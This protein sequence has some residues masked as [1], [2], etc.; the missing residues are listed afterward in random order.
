MEPVQEAAG[1]SILKYLD[2]SIFT[3][4]RRIN[5]IYNNKQLIVYESSD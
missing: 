5:L 3:V 1:G 4:L 2:Q